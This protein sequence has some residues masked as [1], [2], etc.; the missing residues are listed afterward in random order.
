MALIF[1]KE[2]SKPS[3]SV[4]PGFSWDRWYAQN[5]KRLAEKRA[6]RYREDTAYR[7]AALERGKSQ[8]KK[9]TAVADPESLQFS[10]S[11]NDMARLLGITVWVLRE[12]RRKDYF[13]EPHHREG[14]LWFKPEHQSLLH[15]L[16]TFFAT[17]GVRVA[18]AKRPVLQEVVALV[19]ANW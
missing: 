8:R 17:H 4:A 15:L 3:P 7:Q 12:W 10:V 2:K 16:H 14:R 11:F 9:K 5:K 13:P 18:E 1:I 6:K 19:Y